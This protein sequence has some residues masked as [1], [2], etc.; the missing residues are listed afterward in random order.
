MSIHEPTLKIEGTALFYSGFE[1]VSS[2][3]PVY[4]QALTRLVL[5][6]GLFDRSVSSTD[7]VIVDSFNINPDDY[8]L[9]LARSL[10]SSFEADDD[11]IH[12]DVNEFKLKLD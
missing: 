12:A 4:L 3:E 5:F 8:G 7:Q 11:Q 10:D 6:H 9:L 1:I 2:L